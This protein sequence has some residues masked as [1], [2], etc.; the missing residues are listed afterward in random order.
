M[1]DRYFHR[2]AVRHAIVPM[3]PRFTRCLSFVRRCAEL[4][5][6]NPVHTVLAPIG[7]IAGR[8]NRV[9]HP[10][11]KITRS[12]FEAIR[13]ELKFADV[14]FK[15]DTFRREIERRGR[16]STN[17]AIKKDVF[18]PAVAPGEYLFFFFFLFFSILQRENE[19]VHDVV[20]IRSVSRFESILMQVCYFFCSLSPTDR[21]L[22]LIDC[23]E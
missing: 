12:F 21:L 11:F 17:N 6:V 10:R 7:Q 14:F 13:A 16:A 22:G 5:A 15:L 4:F 9:N 23:D 20:P 1:L 18:R 3:V 2:Y 8:A 19:H